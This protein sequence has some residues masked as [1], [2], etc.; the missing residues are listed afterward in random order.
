MELDTT[1]K[2]LCAAFH[3]SL[4]PGCSAIQGVTMRS[5][6]SWKFFGMHRIPERISDHMRFKRRNYISATKSSIAAT[7]L[8]TIA[9]QTRNR[10]QSALLTSTELSSTSRFEHL[11]GHRKSSPS[12]NRSM[13]TCSLQPA[14]TVTQVD[15]CHYDILICLILKLRAG[16]TIC[17]H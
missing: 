3:L 5:T 11:Y 14:C 4:G 2:R 9:D 7:S 16:N 17:S 13:E 10:N 15:V 12:P 8:P 6:Q 1:K